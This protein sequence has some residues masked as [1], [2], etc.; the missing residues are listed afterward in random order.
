MSIPDHATIL[1]LLDELDDCIADDLEC[2]FLDF[3]PTV[4][5]TSTGRG[6][7]AITPCAALLSICL[8]N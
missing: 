6:I 3:K 4:V 1:T 5:W 2:Q 8:A 7:S